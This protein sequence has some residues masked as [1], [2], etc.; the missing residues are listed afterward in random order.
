[1]HR[2]SF[3]PRFVSWF[4]HRHVLTLDID[5]INIVALTVFGVIHRFDDGFTYGESFW[6]TV[7]STVV[8]V[9]TNVTLIIDLICTPNFK[10]SGMY[11]VSFLH[12]PP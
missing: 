10:T 8:S 3:H 4:E 2:V 12:S 6:M 9:I 1:M 5:I 7:C 11:P